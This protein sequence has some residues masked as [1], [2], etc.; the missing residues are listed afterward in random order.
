M[1]IRVSVAQ[2]QKGVPQNPQFTNKKHK[3]R[4]LNKLLANIRPCI[5]KFAVGTKKSQP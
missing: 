4:S 2:K 5:G 3:R 1:C